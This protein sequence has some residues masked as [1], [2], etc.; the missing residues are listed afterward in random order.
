MDGCKACEV[1]DGV[2]SDTCTTE[3]ADCNSE[4]RTKPY[5]K[6]MTTAFE[7]AVSG[8]Q[9][10]A[11]DYLKDCAIWFDG[12]NKCKVNVDG[13]LECT[14]MLCDVQEKAYCVE[15][16]GYVA[17]AKDEKQQRLESCA[18]WYN[19]C[20]YCDVKDGI[21]GQCTRNKCT[22]YRKPYFLSLQ[23]LQGVKLKIRCLSFTVDT[24][25]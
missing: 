4:T 1:K 18:Q 12:C 7:S 19:G 2:P 9:G 3:V 21:L 13:K 8:V 15:K 11:Q 25:S 22:L 16:V 24:M 6:K 10:E 20:N 23:F 5:C 17:P 14:K